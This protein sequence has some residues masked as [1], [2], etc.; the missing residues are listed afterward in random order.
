MQPHQAVYGLSQSLIRFQRC[1][2]IVSPERATIAVDEA[3]APLPAVSVSSC[4]HD[5]AC[6]ITILDVRGIKAPN[7]IKRTIAHYPHRQPQHYY[8]DTFLLI[9][10]RQTT[11]ATMNAALTQSAPTMLSSKL[12]GSRSSL[13][14]RNTCRMPAAHRSLVVRAQA[15]PPKVCFPKNGISAVGTLSVLHRVCVLATTS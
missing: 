9:Q 7:S 14:S 8:L 4:C 6:Q 5:S 10:P 1:D 3:S 2:K 13:L 11:I 15:E 12:A